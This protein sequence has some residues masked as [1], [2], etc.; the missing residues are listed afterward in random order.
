MTRSGRGRLA[1]QRLGRSARFS[2]R[3]C[4]ILYLFRVPLPE[5]QQTTSLRLRGYNGGM[6]PKTRSPAPARII[7][8]LLLLAAPLVPT[9]PASAAAEV[10]PTREQA[11]AVLHPYSA[12]TAAETPGGSSA[13]DRSTL[14]GKVMC[15]YQGWFTAPGDGSGHRLVPLRRPRQ[16]RPRQLLHRPLARRERARRRRNL[17]HALPSRRRLAAPRVQLPQPPRPC[18]GT[19]AGCATTASTASSSSGSPSRRPARPRCNHCN[20]VLDALPRGGQPGGAGATPSCTICPACPPA[21]PIASSTTG[22]CWWTRCAS[23][24]TKPTRPTC[25]TAASRWWRSGASASTTA[26]S[27][28]WTSA[29]D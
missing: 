14:A 20:A 8:I 11:L 25:T 19:S 7:G 23:A 17:L 22:N 29:A 21:A 4:T 9:S 2:G 28:R 26:A 18:C 3:R 12:D 1:K 24:A 10:Q 13:T 15:G 5:S 16:V 6:P 27:T